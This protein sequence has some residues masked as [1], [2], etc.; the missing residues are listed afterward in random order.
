MS[1]APRIDLRARTIL[2]IE[3]VTS[4]AR[5]FK[6]LETLTSVPS[7]TWRSFW[8]RDGALP[9]GTMLE[10]IGRAWPQFAFWLLTGLDDWQAG[11][12]APTTATHLP[13]NLR[14][15]STATTAYFAAR[16]QAENPKPVEATWDRILETK[17][18]MEILDQALEMLGGPEGIDSVRQTLTE[19]GV[20]D[21]SSGTSQDWQIEDGKIIQRAKQA[22]TMH[23][24]REGARTMN[25]LKS[26]RAKDIATRSK[27]ESPKQ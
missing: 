17:R 21:P 19:H 23:M 11:H 16:I 13:E 2:L 27:G 24:D 12:V 7:A 5:R 15:E 3:A 1:T 4:Q 14:W 26:E 18:D 6:E 9:S 25:N 20:I 8:N 22:A 10:E